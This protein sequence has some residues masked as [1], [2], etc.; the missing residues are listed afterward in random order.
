LP[1][2]VLSLGMSENMGFSHLVSLSIFASYFFVILG[3]FALIIGDLH[4][5]AASSRVSVLKKSAF[6]GLTVVSLGYTWYCEL[7]SSI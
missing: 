4:K 7:G 5:L 1:T 3:L 2:E 6:V